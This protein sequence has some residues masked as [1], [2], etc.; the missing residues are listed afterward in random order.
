MK[1][2]CMPI[3]ANGVYKCLMVINT[4]LTL[5]IYEHNI[6]GSKGLHHFIITDIIANNNV[7]D[8]KPLRSV[9]LLC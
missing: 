6:V 3:C 5:S 4:C 1:V 9:C 7:P 2:I 8:F